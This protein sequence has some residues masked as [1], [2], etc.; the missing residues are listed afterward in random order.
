M[1]ADIIHQFPER[2]IPFDVFIA[3]TN[4]DGPVKPLVD[5]SN[6]YVQQNG[7]E[8]QTNEQKMRAF[9]GINYIMSINKNYQQ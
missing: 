2:H 9:L 1:K 8:F 7:R 6:L 4:F 3:V 5:K